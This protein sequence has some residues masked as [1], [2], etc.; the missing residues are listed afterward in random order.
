V[1]T[2]SVFSSR[3]CSVSW[4]PWILED[5][6]SSLTHLLTSLSTGPAKAIC[7]LTFEAQRHSVQTEEADMKLSWKEK[8]RVYS[9]QWYGFK[10]KQYIYFSPYTGTT[11]TI[12]SSNCPSFSCAN[13]SS[14]LILTPGPRGQFPRWCR[15]RKRLSVCSVLRCP[16]LWLQCSVSFLHCN[17]RSGHLKTEHTE[18]LYLLRRHLGNWLRCMHEK[19]TRGSAWE[20][21]TVAA[22]DGVSCDRLRWEINILLTFESVLFFC[23]YPVYLSKRKLPKFFP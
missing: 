21:W 2:R 15:S 4:K 8:Y 16:N 6:T 20:T 18:S 11:Y 1:L 14:L 19:Q 22:T 5:I 10:S 7:S 3:H 17:H 9:K 12:S 13:N 23:V